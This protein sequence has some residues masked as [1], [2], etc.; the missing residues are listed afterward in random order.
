MERLKTL[1]AVIL[2]VLI[3]GC[4]NSAGPGST[5]P[6]DLQDSEVDFM[7]SAAPEKENDTPAQS[8]ENDILPTGHL[9]GKTICIDPGHCVTN[10][11][12]QEKISPKSNETKNVFGGGTSGRNQ[13]E[14]QLN[15]KV[16][17]L[18]KESLKAEGAEVLMTREVSDIAINNI[19]RAQIGNKADCC[20]RIHADGVDDPSVHGISV[21]VPSGDMLGTPEIIT[22]SRTLGELMRKHLVEQTGAKDRGVVDRSDLVGFNWSEV[23]VVLIEMGFM[24]NPEEDARLETEAYQQLLVD[25]MAAAVIEWFSDGPSESN[26]SARLDDAKE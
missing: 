5:E 12:Q 22:P 23:P 15:L 9:A 19:E 3:S 8:V 18:L 1:I 2:L 26:D 21:L 17:L 16:G 20:I 6:P 4:S 11:K 24:T 14:E 10:E 13:T 7:P 25:G